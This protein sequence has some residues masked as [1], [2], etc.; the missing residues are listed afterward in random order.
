VSGRSNSGEIP[1]RFRRGIAWNLVATV[2]S[3]GS[4]FVANILIASTIGQ[5]QFGR[6]GI[7]LSTI[8]LLSAFSGLSLGYAAT[9]YLAEFRD[10]DVTRAGRV[11][12]NAKLGIYVL[13]L[14]MAGALALFAGSIA[15]HLLDAPDLKPLLRVAA[16]AVFFITV[17]GF[18]TGVLSGLEAYRELAWTS[19]LAAVCYLALCA[20]GAVVWGVEG[21]VAGLALSAIIQWL[22]VGQAVRDALKRFGIAA[23]YQFGEEEAAIVRRFLL[24]GAISGLTAAP[25][26]WTAQ[27]VLA[28]SNSGFT[29]MA[30]Y[31]AA[32]NL[33]AIVLFLPNVANTVG[34]TLLNHVL[35]RRDGTLFKDVFW[36]NLWA[37]LLVAGIGALGILAVAPW[38]LRAYGTGFQAALPVLAILLTAALP[39]ALTLA[40]NQLLQSR[41][42]MWTAILWVNIPRDSLI[43]IAAFALV[44]RYGARGLAAAYLFG[45]VIALLAI[46]I[47]AYRIGGTRITTAAQPREVI[48]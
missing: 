36:M 22:L 7:V 45:R 33:M 30:L 2:A 46:V 34:M 8:Q 19:G 14:L 3:Q 23:S 1:Q 40:L 9:R 10:T 16:V 27:A 15:L 4:T 31:T 28:R 29:E 25:A 11:Y 42:R 6:Y 18:R 47:A 35:S 37:S 43:V 32:Y 5:A 17:S 39:E 38:L 21:A 44:P 26:L 20:G 13:A 48:A 12:G 41:E 24:P